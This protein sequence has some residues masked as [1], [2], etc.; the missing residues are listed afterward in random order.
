[1]V[2]GFNFMPSFP[3]A[4]AHKSGRT[5]AGAACGCSG[6][7]EVTSTGDFVNSNLGIFPGLQLPLVERDCHPRRGLVTVQSV[8]RRPHDPYLLHCVS[9]S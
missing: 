9:F 1:M 2:F 4:G 6:T 3:E 5:Q 8:G 7:L